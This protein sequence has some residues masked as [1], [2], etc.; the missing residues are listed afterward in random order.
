VI[1]RVHGALLVLGALTFA[2]EALADDGCH[3]LAP[4]N[5]VGSSLGHFIEPVPL[6][7]TALS[8]LPLVL[9][10]PT[11]GDHALRLVAQQDL[12]G[13]Y[14]LESVSVYTPYVLAGGAL[15][16]FGLSA[17]FG[18]CEVERPLSAILQGM[19]GGLIA[20]GLLK[21]GVGRQWPTG[22]QDPYAADRLAHSEYAREFYPFRFLGAW[23]SGHTLSM[24][25]AAAAFR[26]AEYELGWLRF[27]GYPLAIGVGA[28]MWL[29]DRHWASDVL[30]G[31][32]LGEAI[33]SSVGRSFA[34]SADASPT[35]FF[36]GTLVAAPV[37]GGMLLEW[38][39]TW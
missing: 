12:G 30:S 15:V 8:P 39:G 27:V 28:G 1:L 22:G 18:A 17:V 32:L 13:R 31:A 21:W 33:G 11:G 3:R 25:A 23:P 36:A 2:P 4:W 16:G 19:A 37:G 34:R 29:G 24:F 10:S 38:L 6:A 9:L 5:R 14:R 20:T 7:L 26:A 35:G